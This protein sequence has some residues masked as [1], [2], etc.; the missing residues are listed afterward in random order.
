[1][2]SATISLADMVR[3]AVAFHKEGRLDE[4][5][6]VYEAVLRMEP[7]NAD[8]LHLLGAIDHQRGDHER[9]VTRIRQAL[10]IYGPRSNY[11]SNLGIGLRALGRTAEAI[12]ALRRAAELDPTSADIQF[13]LGNAC[14]AAGEFAQAVEAFRAAVARNPH[15]AAAWSGWG[16]ALRET[17]DFDESRR[18]HE[19]A[20][21]LS[22]RSADVHFNLGLTCRDEG[23][24]AEAADCFLRALALRPDFTDAHVALG[25]LRE[26]VGDFGRAVASYDRVLR[27]QPQLTA[28]QFNRSLALLRQGRLAEGWD[29]Y[30]SRWRHN[31][32][33]RLFAESEWDGSLAKD[34][35][36]LV[37]SEQGVGDEI[38][39]ASCFRDIIER[40]GVCLIECEPRLVRLF[41]RSFPN[42]RFFARTGLVDPSQVRDLPPFDVQIVAGS[43]PRRLRRS[44]DSFPIHSGYLTPEPRQVDEWRTRFERLG[45]GLVVGISWRGGKDAAIRRRRSTALA[46]WAPL[47]KIPG[48]AFVNLQYGDCAADIADCARDFGVTLHTWEDAD[49]LHD[50]DGFAAQI[51]ALDLVVS[52]DNATVHMSGALNT[53][54]WTLLPFSGDWRWFSQGD[55]SPWYPSVRLFRQ[56]SFR[57]M[58]LGDWN[59]V[60]HRVSQA[61]ENL[62][63]QRADEERQRATGLHGE[64]RLAEAIQCY[65]RVAALR[66]GHA[67]TLNDLGVAWKD[68][69]RS[70]L[71]VAAYRQAIDAQPDFAIPWFNCGNAHREDNHLTDAVACYQEAHQREPENPQI[72]VN[73]AV[74]LKDLRRLEESAD[75]LDEALR[76]FPELPEARFDRSLIHLL[77]GELGKGWDEYEWRMKHGPQPP[78][79]PLAR[80]DGA[81]LA[82]RQI[83]ILPEQGIGD[84][85]MFGTCLPQ[86]ASAAAACFFQCDPRLVPLFARSLPNVIPLAKTADPMADPA[87]AGCG[88]YDFVG[89]LPR[90][91]RRKVEDFPQ[92]PTYLKP[93][94]ALVAS[95]QSQ[96]ARCGRALK[97][98]ISWRGGQDAAAR[99]KRS[100][101]LELWGPVFQVPGVRFVNLQYGS[102][103][104]DAA[105]VRDRFGVALDDGRD[106]DPLVDL[107]GFTAKIAALDLVLSVDNSTVHLAAAIGRPVWTLLPYGA[108]WR[109]MLEGETT[110]WYPTMCLLR[111]RTHDGWAELLQR[112]ARRLTAATFSQT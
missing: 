104:A 23:K 103:A 85:V 15:N 12:D 34:K 54:V 99:R 8:A 44:L 71:A 37:Y 25:N 73:L 67:Q 110:P 32:K 38:L 42:A 36:I 10:A 101:P 24:A 76:K 17:R 63:T 112:A 29:A 50:L 75:C 81:S 35:T 111:C 27:L 96:F 107:D 3:D 82:G 69:G 65:L 4:A 88:L 14:Q 45:S 59:E 60:F 58:A 46:Q 98:G 9:A 94:S 90:I 93:D 66:P 105:L 80:W 91:L 77:R 72:L 22:P 19:R 64:G 100:I 108:D 92:T 51:A 61:L 47:F 102:S 53:P 41:T 39:F 95:W 26:D 55:E 86:V 57:E 40:T 89:S 13:N 74:A 5:A 20:I 68:G 56:T 7:R 1:M 18:C 48:I 16:E 30:E 31:G 84:E 83:L 97:V 70:D 79:I 21:S 49:P 62:A 33:P 87:V 11:L 2:A 28:A 78:P 106:C 109:W 52:V 43:V 6:A